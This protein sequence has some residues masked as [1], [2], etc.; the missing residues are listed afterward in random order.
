VPSDDEIR[1]SM[2]TLLYTKA[3]KSPRNSC[4]GSTEFVKA[5]NVPQNLIEFNWKYLE[6]EKLIETVS[7]FERRRPI[8]A[9]IISSGMKFIEGKDKEENKSRFSFLRATIPI[10]IKIK[11][12]LIVQ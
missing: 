9:R 6:G 8:G 2:L 4:V 5:L 10:P 3:K 12:G 1:I 7:L 11:I